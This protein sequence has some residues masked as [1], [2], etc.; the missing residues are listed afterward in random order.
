MLL[1]GLILVF[2][3]LQYYFSKQSS[4]CVRGRANILLFY[5]ILHVMCMLW[6]GVYLLSGENVFA[7]STT[8]VSLAFL[9]A[10]SLGVSMAANF[11]ALKRGSVL[12]VSVFA[13]LG[14]VFPCIFGWTVLHEPFRLLQLCGMLL[15]L[16]GIFILLDIKKIKTMDFKLLLLV[17][18]CALSEGS[19]MIAQQLYARRMPSNTNATFSALM[20]GFTSLIFL[21]LNL[22]FGRKEQRPKKLGKK[23]VGYAVILSVLLFLINQFV[24]YASSKIDSAILFPIVS[25]G[26]LLLGSVVGAV[27][28]QEKFTKR[29]SIAL[30]V[31]ICAVVLL[32]IG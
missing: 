18:L 2:K 25:G 22:V 28:F 32:N 10:V 30:I 3:T 27:C 24:I 20:F 6:S 1:T 16:I 31:S 26:A 4:V 5:L 19:T 21:L 9:A 15:L 29:N 7:L 12:L 13:S 8:T 23:Q 11:L 17:L 14:I